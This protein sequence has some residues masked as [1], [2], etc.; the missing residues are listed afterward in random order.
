MALHHFFH[1]TFPE[2]GNHCAGNR[3]NRGYHENPDS[4]NLTERANAT[5]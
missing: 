5:F 4:Q 3:K 1:G 2:E